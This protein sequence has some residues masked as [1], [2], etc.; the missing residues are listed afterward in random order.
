MPDTPM[1]SQDD[2]V[3]LEVPKKKYQLPHVANFEDVNRNFDSLSGM[4]TTMLEEMKEHSETT[5]K[6]LTR[7]AEETS[8]NLN[9]LA[10]DMKSILSSQTMM[11]TIC[12]IFV[13]FIIII[14]KGAFD[15]VSTFFFA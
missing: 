7:L 1:S 14:A 15:A 13:C 4:V 8:E 3:T 11:L 10:D 9:K 5:N 6:N 2:S 12:I